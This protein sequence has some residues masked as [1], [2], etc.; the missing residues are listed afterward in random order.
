MLIA[1]LKKKKNKKGELLQE[2]TFF[3]LGKESI[4]AYSHSN[5]PAV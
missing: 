2:F 5:E 4:S 3:I 1:T